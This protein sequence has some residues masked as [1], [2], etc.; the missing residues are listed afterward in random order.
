LVGRPGPRW[1][2]MVRS[3]LI[4]G[5]RRRGMKERGGRKKEGRGEKG[6]ERGRGG[7][8]EKDGKGK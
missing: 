8:K 4:S 2:L 1:E 7:L 5:L 6:R 3:R